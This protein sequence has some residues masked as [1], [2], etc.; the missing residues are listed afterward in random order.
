MKCVSTVGER[1]STISRE[2]LALFIICIADT[3]STMALVSKGL[4][5]EAN[6]WMRH[7]LECGGVA[8]FLV[9]MVP[10]AALIALAEWR[11]RSRP[12]FVRRALLVAVI[13]YVSA[14]AISMAAV[15]VV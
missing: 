6:P 13:I 8:F 15:N 12:Q 3:L 14:Y 4:A 2:S 5:V 11:K 1:A 10:V 9:K 7:C